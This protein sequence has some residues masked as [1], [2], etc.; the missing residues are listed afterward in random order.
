MPT[1]ASTGTGQV[2]SSGK[3]TAKSK[4]DNADVKAEKDTVPAVDADGEVKAEVSEEKAAEVHQ[5]K[6]DYAPKVEQT[7]KQSKGKSDLNSPDGATIKTDPDDVQPGDRADLPPMPPQDYQG[8]VA[9]HNNSGVVH[10]VNREGAFVSVAVAD[11]D[12]EK[13]LRAADPK[14][15]SL[16]KD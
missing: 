13:K 8:E 4:K 14:H 2:K 9:D 3:S 16:P 15:P 1:S 12:Y 6:P 7:P 11:P 10:A 5:I